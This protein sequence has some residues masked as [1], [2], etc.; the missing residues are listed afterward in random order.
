MVHQHEHPHIDREIQSTGVGKGI[1]LHC[2]EQAWWL[3][4]I[5]N[6]TSL[7]A[8]IKGSLL[9]LMTESRRFGAELPNL[10]I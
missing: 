5:A 3:G 6:Q 10:P 4:S 9:S 1:L 7:R 2:S 8:W